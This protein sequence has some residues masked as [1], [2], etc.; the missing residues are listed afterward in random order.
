MSTKKKAASRKK[1][2][3]AHDSG[4]KPLSR[5]QDKV[6]FY[7]DWCKRCGNCS[8]F[9][10]RQAIDQN[11][12]GYPYLADPDRCTQC[13]LCEMLCPD[14]ALSVGE[15]SPPVGRRKSQPP[16]E[17]GQRGPL[18]GSPER[19][20]PKARQKTVPPKSAKSRGKGK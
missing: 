5:H 7:P 15:A 11:Q 17:R 2:D 3:A 13:G 16:A 9:C 18:R 20:A 12:W 14:F 6:T 10:P 19:V 8:A 1:T 4:E